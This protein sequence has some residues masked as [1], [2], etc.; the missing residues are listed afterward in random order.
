MN[1]LFDIPTQP[2]RTT[3]EPKAMRLARLRKKLDAVE[4]DLD[5]AQD[6]VRQLESLSEALSD[7]IEKIE[8]E[9]DFEQ[10]AAG[11]VL[12]RFDG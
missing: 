3:V 7:E 8:N 5:A 2:K 11:D 9:P 4:S 12:S 6:E 1:T 10:D